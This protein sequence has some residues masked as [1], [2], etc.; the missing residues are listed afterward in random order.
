MSTR[1]RVHDALVC[2]CVF[3]NGN[4]I[5][6]EIAREK[7]TSIFCRFFLCA[8]VHPKRVSFLA[9]TARHNQKFTRVRNAANNGQTRTNRTTKK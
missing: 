9:F 4:P 5:D 8:V 6:F 7:K 1:E 2:V 3:A